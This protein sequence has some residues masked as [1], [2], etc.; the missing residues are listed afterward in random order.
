MRQIVFARY[1]D[2]ADVLAL[3][4]RPAPEPGPR[5]VRVR[6]LARP[7]NPSD[8]LL[9]EGRYGRPASFAPGLHPDGVRTAAAV[10]FEGVGVV[11]RAGPDAH[12][13]VGTRVAVS[14][15]GTWAEY[16]VADHR[17]AHPVPP[18]LSD[19]AAC[20]LTVNP[21]TAN[22]M[23][24]DLALE[25]KDLVLFTA[26]ASSVARM[27][28]RLAHSRGARCIG[29]VRD[30]RHRRPLMEAGAFA[31]LCEDEPD[32]ERQLSNIATTSGI[33]AVV[34]AVGGPVADLSL[35]ALCPHGR[36]VSYGLLSGLPV[37]V[38]PEDLVFRGITMTGF[39]LPE[40]L[41]RLTPAQVTDA[42]ARAAVQLA[43]GT[44]DVPRAETFDLSDFQAA[45]RH[46]R[47]PGHL[48]KAVLVG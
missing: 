34:D 30:L 1:G 41:S 24:E 16:V 26:A 31:V 14:A 8:L 25:P 29:L 15:Q 39:W 37:T 17:D 22:L 2:P 5:Q 48:S 4:H 13:S 40:R 6:M 35:R 28:I 11:D 43:D 36:F 3:A 32:L 23:L 10:G 20:R 44:I 7:V 47:E 46:S 18:G 38:R 21:V 9:V 19:A 27:M 45:V 42:L 33:R 12:H